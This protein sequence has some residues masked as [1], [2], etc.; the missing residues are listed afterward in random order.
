MN[1][2]NL[3][4]TN[5]KIELVSSDFH[6]FSL[7]QYFY[8]LGTFIYLCRYIGFNRAL[9]TWICDAILFAIDFTSIGTGWAVKLNWT[10]PLFLTNDNSYNN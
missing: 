7:L 10:H 4:F 3:I 5:Q 6:M 1:Y 9:F 8:N 2:S